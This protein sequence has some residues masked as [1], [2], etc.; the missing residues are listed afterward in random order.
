MNLLLFAAEELRANILTLE[1]HRAEHIV[2]VL[3]LQQ[4]DRLRL[5]MIDGPRG[6]GTILSISPAAVRLQ[7]TLDDHVPVRPRLDLI[8]ALPRPIMLKRIF[9][10]ATVLGVDHIH[11]INSRRVEKSF[12]KASILKPEK[13]RPLLIEGLSQ[14]MDTAL[15]K[16][17]VHP[18][19]KPFIEEV[20]PSWNTHHRLIAHPGDQQHQK[21]GGWPEIHGE[22]KVVLAVGP[23]GGWIDYELR[24]FAEQGFR[25]FSLGPR[26]LHVDTAV[27][28]LLARIELLRELGPTLFPA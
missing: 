20:V 12:F 26:I 5:G 24:R 9:K 15:P 3:D 14:A 22:D 27:I 13:Y 19:F 4:G 6:H 23:E 11:L 18:L 8:L 21:T 17:S 25:T 28:A 2:R 16:I 1:D 7:V 10:Q